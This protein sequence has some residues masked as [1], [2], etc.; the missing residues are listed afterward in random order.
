MSNLSYVSTEL[1]VLK[2]VNNQGFIIST[3][4]FL[5]LPSSATRAGKKL[6]L[7]KQLLRK[8]LPKGSW[9]FPI[10]FS[11]PSPSHFPYRKIPLESKPNYSYHSFPAVQ[12]LD[13]KHNGVVMPSLHPKG[14]STKT[15][16]LVPFSKYAHTL[17]NDGHKP[18]TLENCLLNLQKMLPLS[19]FCIRLHGTSFISKLPK[20]QSR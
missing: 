6:L 19:S 8:D 9:H 16:L 17:T 11:I 20:Y 10:N 13:R 7:C 5:L 12:S 4:L 18:F 3:D 1:P 2:G 15:E 14:N